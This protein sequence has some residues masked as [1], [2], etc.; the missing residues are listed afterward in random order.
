MTGHIEGMV[1]KAPQEP[2]VPATD[3]FNCRLPQ[4]LCTGLNLKCALSR[5]ASDFVVRCASVK[6]I[7]DMPMFEPEMGHFLGRQSLVFW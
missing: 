5:V 4:L 6:T 3:I 2:S 7:F 1:K